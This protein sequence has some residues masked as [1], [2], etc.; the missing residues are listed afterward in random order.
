MFG[1]EVPIECPGVPA[2]ILIPRKTWSDQAEYDKS[3]LRLAALFQ[4][5]FETYADQA[6][7]EIRDAGPRT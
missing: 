7:A 6:S 1:L 2:E 3:R 5:N 4:T